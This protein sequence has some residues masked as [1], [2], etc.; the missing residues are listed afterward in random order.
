MFCINC[1]FK[2]EDDMIFCPKCGAKI[3]KAEDCNEKKEKDSLN[4]QIHKLET[5]YQ[6]KLNEKNQ[7]K[8]KLEK[9]SLKINLQIKEIWQEVN[10][11]LEAVEKENLT[12]Y[13]TISNENTEELLYC[14]NC[15]YYVKNANF[16]PKCGTKIQE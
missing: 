7:L 2:L 1:G 11:Q 8:D 15:G 10:R 14:P 6:E 16:C 3:T 12:Q 9:E 4:D 13:K 5:E